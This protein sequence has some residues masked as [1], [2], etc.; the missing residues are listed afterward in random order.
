MRASRCPVCSGPHCLRLPDPGRTSMRSDGWIVA[1]PLRKYSCLSCG[2]VFRDRRRT[3]A[4]AVDAD[5]YSLNAKADSSFDQSRQQSYAAI[6]T[7]AVH[8]PPACV[9]DIGCGN[10]ALLAQLR[11]AWP[12]A[13]AVGIE[14]AALPRAA[15]AARGID[16]RSGLDHAPTAD[17]VVSVNVIEHTPDPAGFLASVAR[18]LAP[19]AHCVIIWPAGEPPSTE[20]LFNDHLFTLSRQVVADL[21]AAQGLEVQAELQAPAGFQGLHL[22]QRG[23]ARRGGIP[24]RATG[25]AFLPLAR[26]RAAYLHRWASLERELLAQI[27][28]RRDLVAFG[29]GESAQTLRAYAPR[30]WHQVRELTAD[31]VQ[32]QRALQ[33]PVRPV[34]TLDPARHQLLL[35]THPRVQGRLAERFVA[36]G[37]TCLRWDDWIQN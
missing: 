32:G 20:L 37:F 17:L 24:M 1:E 35:A 5:A 3:Y 8:A 33:L 22:R 36:A 28:S 34:S 9:I 15:A 4:R 2:T 19:G 10:G 21:A 14:P 11:E 25:R 30:A 6:I 23:R 27:D 26:R 7:A 31:D 16:V 18:A 12:D 29:L 13:R